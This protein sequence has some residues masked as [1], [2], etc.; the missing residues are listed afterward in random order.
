METSELSTC[1]VT[2][3]VDKCVEFYKHNFSAQEVFNC[4]W[5]VDMRINGDGPSIQFMQPQEG[6]SVFGGTGTILNFNVS[7][8]DDEYER[9]V[10]NAGL[11]VVMPLEDHPWGDRGFSIIDPIGNAI[12]IYSEREPSDEF[13][14]YFKD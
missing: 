7:N 6:M 2:T 10:K 13:K 5:Y 4:G 12:Y 14:Q 1:F 9:L 11:Q 3:E 8:V